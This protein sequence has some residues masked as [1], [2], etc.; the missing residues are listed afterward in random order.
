MLISFLAQFPESLDTRTRVKALA[1][2]ET[3]QRLALMRYLWSF[4]RRRGH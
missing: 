3:R 4:I 2:G 1:E